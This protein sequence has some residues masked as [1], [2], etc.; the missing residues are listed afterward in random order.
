MGKETRRCNTYYDKIL[1]NSIKNKIN[2][3]E[4]IASITF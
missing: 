4:I 3:E 2:F 1:R